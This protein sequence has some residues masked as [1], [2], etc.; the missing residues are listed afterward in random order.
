MPTPVRPALLGLAGLA[1]LVAAGCGG[2]DGGMDPSPYPAPDPLVLDTTGLLP[3]PATPGNPLT[4]QG[5]ELGRKLFH[6]PILSGDDTQ[7][8][9]SCHAQAFAFTDHGLPFSFGI[10]GSQGT[11]NAPPIINLAWARDLFW[12]GRAV[13][14]EA[15]AVEPV[16][17]PIEM[18]LPWDQA[19]AKVSAHP[20]YPAMFG[21]AF[22]DEE[23]TQDR[24][25]K[26]IAQFER[27]VLSRD[28]RLDQKLRREVTFT[29]EEARGE[30]LFFSERG[31]CFHCHGSILLTDNQFHDNGLDLVPADPGRFLVTG[32][33]FDRGKFRT[34]TL[35]NIE[36]TAPYMHDGR[37]ATL[38]EVIDHYSDGVQD[39][40]NLDPLLRVPR[41]PDDSP[42]TAQEK[43]DLI[44]FLKT[45]TDPVFIANPDYG[46]PGP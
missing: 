16:P 2:G 7:S 40:P 12:A 13:G 45:F 21:R 9:A 17:N 1:A 27:T 38:E 25:V 32:Q 28:S 29:P 39:S 18:K 14:L 15:Q 10:D 34:P 44:A 33:E 11:R 31:D 46:P 3:L 37:F 20:E 42:F 30:Q 35:R 41:P 24:I 19:V 43:A 26:A 6:D 22:G 8:C 4:V 36:L 5:V 23:V